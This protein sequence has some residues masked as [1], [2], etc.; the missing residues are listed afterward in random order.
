[1]NLRK[2]NYSVCLIIPL[3][4]GLVACSSDDSSKGRVD[5]GDD[6]SGPALDIVETAIDDGRF[7]IL[8]QAVTT[9]NLV[10]T[11]QSDGP[12]TVFA[13]TDDAFVN[14]LTAADITA[15]DLLASPDLGDILTY[16]VLAS[17]VLADVAT[18]LAGGTDNIQATV[19]GQ[20]I[21]LSLSGDDLYINA[22]KVIVPDVLASNGVIH[23]LN[24]VLIPP[25]AKPE[26]A[27]IAC[28]EDGALDSISTI[29]GNLGFSTLV[30]A[31]MAA[32]DSVL[33]ALSSAGALTVFAPTND[34]FNKID[35]MALTDLLANTTALTE[36][37]LNH[38]YDGAVDAVSAY[39]LNGVTVP[40]LG[41]GDLAISID[42][43][44]LKV[45]DSLVSGTD[46]YACNGIIHAIDTVIL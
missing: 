22:S 44:G 20:S 34:A 30:T 2:F 28:G 37:L 17:E 25:A 40:A 16:H 3:I 4:F 23:A 12:F 19:N 5:D 32:E 36:V 39:S 38:V 33:T 18:D 9:A 27:S 24:K 13:P 21:A 10:D 8:V 14:Y 35:E 11:L 42:D 41:G 7:E 1:M 31:V 43:D 46:I 26:A 45:T 29:A 15:D 6:N